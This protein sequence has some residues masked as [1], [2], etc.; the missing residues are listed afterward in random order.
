MRR[1]RRALTAVVTAAAVAA[2]GLTATAL[3]SSSPAARSATGR[4]STV[5]LRPGSGQLVV[6]WNREL[7]AIAGNPGTQPA[8][9]HLTR[10]LAILHISTPK[11]GR[12]R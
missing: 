8:T 5:A 1:T 7:I 11:P 6:D 2:A 3:A 4:Q 9:V 10:S 12:A